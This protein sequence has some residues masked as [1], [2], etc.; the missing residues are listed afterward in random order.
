MVIELVNTV[1]EVTFY[2][3]IQIHIDTSNIKKNYRFDVTW[4]CGWVYWIGRGWPNNTSAANKWVV[5]VC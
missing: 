4:C 2:V 1:D 3:K 5:G